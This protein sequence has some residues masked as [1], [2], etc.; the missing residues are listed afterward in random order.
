MVADAFQH[1]RFKYFPEAGEDPYHSF[2]GVP[3]VEGGE[4]AGRARRPDD[5]AAH[6]LAQNEIRMLVTVA[7]QVAALVGDARLLEQVSAAAHEAPTA[8]PPG[9]VSRSAPS[10]AASPLSPGVGVGEA[11][12]V[13]GFDEWRADRA[14][15]ER[16]PGAGET[17]AGARPWRRPATRSSASASASPSWSARTTAPSS[18]PS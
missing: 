1:P 15:N 7:A 5:G 12:V 13:D 9:R 14:A 8:A 18:T 4:L 11:Y 16:R 3:L 2:L 10:F 17:A 6:L